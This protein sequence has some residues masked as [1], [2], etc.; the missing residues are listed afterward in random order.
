MILHEGDPLQ[1]HYTVSSCIFKKLMGFTGWMSP[2]SP[3]ATSI[4]ILIT[5]LDSYSTSNSI[6]KHQYFLAHY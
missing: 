5:L 2:R 1:K 3:K 6:K 4:P